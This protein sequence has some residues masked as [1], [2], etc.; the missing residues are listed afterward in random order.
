MLAA[1]S[2][3]SR[4]PRHLLGLPLGLLLCLLACAG[5]AERAPDALRSSGVPA[6]PDT[7]GAAAPGAPAALEDPAAA[8][9]GD[10]DLATA[11]PPASPPPAPRPADARAVLD[12]PASIA[13]LARWAEDADAGQGVRLTALRR[14][15]REG[16]GRA[17]DVAARLLS[18][19][20]GDPQLRANAVAVLARS[21]DPRADA[22]LARQEPRYQQLAA[23]LR[24]RRPR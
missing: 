22:V 15:E 5:C 11:E 19:T 2:L 6:R 17:T 24:E 20:P 21:S 7:G 13:D 9:A 10:A 3:H 18:E 23:R 1:R 12:R 16:P 4:A 8:S 14:L